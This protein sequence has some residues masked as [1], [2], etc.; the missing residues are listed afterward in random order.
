MEPT[1]C[2]RDLEEEESFSHSSPYHSFHISQ[3]R[4]DNTMVIR[5]T[6]LARHTTRYVTHGT[7]SNLEKT[8][9][10]SGQQIVVSALS[11]VSSPLPIINGCLLVI[12]S[13][14]LRIPSRLSLL[15]STTYDHSHANANIRKNKSAHI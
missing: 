14:I 11:R 10:N 1:L 2:V 4:N 6:F 3:V 9:T 5:D 13:N 8:R 15:E 12:D 7:I